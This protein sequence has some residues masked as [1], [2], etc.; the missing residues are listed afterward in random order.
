MEVHQ[1][2]HTPRNKWTHYF[3]EFFMLFLAVI[4]GFFVENQRE[5]YI[6][7]SREKQF[8]RSLFNDIK[9]D[10]AS[11]SRIINARTAKER[12]ADSLSYLMNR[13]FSRDITREIYYYAVSISRTLPY[14]FVPN[15][16]TMQQLKNSGALRLIRNRAVVDSIAKYDV[17]VRNFLRQGDVEETVI[18]HYR[19]GAT[20]IFDALVFDQMLDENMNVVRLPAE[21]PGLQPFSNRELYEWNYR[22]FSLKALNKASRRD[23]RVLLRQGNNLL[24]TLKEAYHFE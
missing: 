5:H 22:L 14:R 1:H 24:K 4:A 8:V 12:A 13:G 19:T 9:V 2:S 18:E 11:L 16:G 20:K 10:T 23:A 15:D 6:E 3:W 17:S 7:L 21:K